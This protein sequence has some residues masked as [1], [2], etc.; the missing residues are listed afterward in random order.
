MKFNLPDSIL[1][2]QDLTSVLL[3]VKDYTR[4]FAHDA[5]KKRISA[6]HSSTEAPIL[7][8]ATAELLH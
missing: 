4:W 6:K 2:A 5:M 7:S 3:E 8:S 1:S